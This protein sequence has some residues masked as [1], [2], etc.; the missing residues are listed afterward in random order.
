MLEKIIES[1]EW[2]SIK[3]KEEK[4]E[5]SAKK[6]MILGFFINLVKKE[7]SIST[8]KVSKYSKCIEKF[9]EYDARSSINFGENLLLCL[10]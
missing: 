4:I 9:V 10:C 3:L 6:M 2:L 7:I 5:G 1:A 8:E